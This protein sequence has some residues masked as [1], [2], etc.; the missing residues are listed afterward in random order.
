MFP[1]VPGE[2]PYSTTALPRPTNFYGETKW[3]GEK[4]VLDEMEKG[5]GKEGKVVVLRVPVLYGSVEDAVG[6]KESAVNVLMDAVWKAQD[7]ELVMDDW[8]IRYPTC[9]ED[10][11]RVCVGLFLSF[12]LPHSI[13][14][15]FSS[16][17]KEF[18]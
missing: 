9:T 14:P 4:A 15:L 8:A 5:K 2:A 18:C 17:Y 3:E 7:G 11:G 10:V 1:G 6:N 12:S 13:L 16:S